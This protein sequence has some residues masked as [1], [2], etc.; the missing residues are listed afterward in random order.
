MSL[1]SKRSKGLQKRWLEDEDESDMNC[2]SAKRRR[3][4][5]VDER[6]RVHERARV[7]SHLAEC[8][9][10]S[11]EFDQAR[12][13]RATLRKLPH[14]RV[15]SNLRLA[16]RVR[17]SQERSAVEN[18][19]GSQLVRLWESWLYRLDE[20]M[21]PITIP[22]TGGLL[23]SLILF[24]A[25]TFTIGTTS[26]GANYEVPVFYADQMEANLV[27]MQLQSSVLL[28]LSLDG[29]GRITDYAFRDKSEAFIGDATRLQYKNIAMPD[30][31][32]VLAITSPINR[33]ISIKFVPIVFRR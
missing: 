17:A 16:L 24:G 1:V 9:S 14:P 5:F 15:P 8:Q 3:E 21:R 18:H 4:D 33:D 12:A 27:P 20:L 22:A 7:V 29:K 28:T 19:Q 30:F 32:S 6:L 2:W 31:P 26:R 13:V 23:S 10:C 25:L 11:L